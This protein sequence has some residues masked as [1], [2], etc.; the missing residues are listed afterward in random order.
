MNKY[1]KLKRFPLGAITASGFIKDQMLLGKD[2]ICG[3][4]HEL[5]PGMIADPLINKTPVPAWLPSNQDGWGAEISGNYWAG[6]IQYAYTLNDPEMIA[7][8]T[9]WV[10]TMMKKQREDGY[11][12]TYYE[13]DAEIY[14]DYNAWGTGCVMRGLLAFH[15]VTGRQDVLDA[16]HRCMLWFCEN[17]SGNKKTT[18]A[19]PFIIEPM[20][21]TY[22]LTGDKRLCEFAEE[23]LKFVDTNDIFESSYRK[24]LEG[25]INYNAFHTAGFGCQSRLPALVYTATGNEDYLKATETAL[26]ELYKKSVQITGS[27]VSD[28]EYNGPVGSIAE[29]EY[30]C[31]AFFNQT[32]SYMSCITGDPKYG[33]RMEEMFYN[34]AQGARKKDEKAIAYMNTPNQVYATPSSSRSASDKQA[35]APCYPTSCCPVNAVA[36]IPE[37]VRG[38]LLHDEEDNVYAMVYGPCELNCGDLSMKVETYYPFRNSVSVIIECDKEFTLN[39]RIPTFSKG[40]TVSVNG[41]EATYVE[42]NGFIEIRR[43][44]EKGDKVTVNFKAEVETVIIDDTDGANKHPIAV[45]Y[46]A[47]VFAYHIPEVWTKYR[48][49][50]MTPLPEGWSWYKVTPDFKEAD[51]SDAHER[52]GLRRKQISW[53]IAVDESI[54]KDDFAVEELP[55]SGYVWANPMIKLHTHCYKAPYLCAPYPGTTFESFGEYQEVTDKLPLTLEPYGCTNLRITYFPKAK[56]D[57]AEKA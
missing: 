5:E 49:R 33:E 57:T 25:K 14:D 6:Y 2:G 54:S 27:P 38:M 50:P 3:H 30:C 56:L 43:I 12:G 47:L 53:N 19:G 16:V 45:K 26:D 46:G 51:V 36:V 1:Q 31:Y 9:D 21:F 42:H 7:V 18:Y 8:A 40:Y 17:W 20:I 11:L 29:T 24:L 28:N 10:N 35:Y 15:E 52:M 4:L 48:G 23:Y 37:F 13:P 22:H 39:L 44:W 32:Y 34:G 41:T 55:E